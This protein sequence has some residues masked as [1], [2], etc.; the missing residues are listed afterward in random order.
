MSARRVVHG[1]A[2]LSRPEP[3]LDSDRRP[4]EGVKQWI[5]RLAA[6]EVPRCLSRLIEMVNDYDVDVRTRRMVNLDL[7]ALA[8]EVELSA[9]ETD[10][11]PGK[12]RVYLVDANAASE[13][14][15]K[16]REDAQ[17]GGQ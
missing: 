10:A 5:A 2:A 14:L 4:G 8:S 12:T 11:A 7:L 6:P 13:H 3:R 1:T 9:D 15:R 16:L 17:R